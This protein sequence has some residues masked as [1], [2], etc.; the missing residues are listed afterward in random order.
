MSEAISH[1]TAPLLRRW[2][3]YRDSAW[4]LEPMARPVYRR[5]LLLALSITYSGASRRRDIFAFSTNIRAGA[6]DEWWARY[7]CL[8]FY[9]L[10]P[11]YHACLFTTILYS[12]AST[13]NTSHYAFRCGISPRLF[14]DA[15]VMP[16]FCLLL[17]PRPTTPPFS[18]AAALLYRYFDEYFLK[19]AESWLIWL[20]SAFILSRADT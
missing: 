11:R 3:H 12:R 20:N 14:D 17:R 18:V 7:R 1:D 15:A 2:F 8:V 16:T 6:L 10:T 19:T 9:A 4:L 5:L 13:D